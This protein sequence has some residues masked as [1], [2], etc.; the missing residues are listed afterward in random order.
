MGFLPSWERSLGIL[1]AVDGSSVNPLAQG[2]EW[3]SFVDSHSIGATT[4]LSQSFVVDG[5]FGYT[6]HDVHVFPPVDTCYGDVFGIPNACQPPY[7][8]D[9]NVP[10]MLVTGWV[11]NG[12]SPIRDYVDP[13]WQF[14][15]NAGWTKGSHN[16][17]FG[18]DY[19]ILHQGHYETQAQHSRSTAA[20]RSCSGG[21][22]TTQQA[23]IIP[24]RNALVANRAGDDP[25]WRRR[26]ER[27]RAGLSP[28]IAS[29]TFTHSNVGRSAAISGLKLE[30][31]QS[32]AG[33]T[34]LFFF[35][36]NQH[37][38]WRLAIASKTCSRSDHA[39]VVSVERSLFPI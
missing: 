21:A 6:K 37:R 33:S 8:L 31:H 19:I 7:S 3:D 36:I 10:D 29:D 11:L 2:R 38:L 20:S 4:I 18:V 27:S 23:A 25:A 12:Q 24:P 9:T 32:F 15:A 14:V 39:T 26:I 28:A 1:P 35:F 17:K 16:V 30:A 34:S 22:A 13:Q 5:S